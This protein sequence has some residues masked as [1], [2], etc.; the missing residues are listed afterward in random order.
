MRDKKWPKIKYI[1]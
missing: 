1:K